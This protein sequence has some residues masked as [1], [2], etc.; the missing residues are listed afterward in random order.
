MDTDKHELLLKD[1]LCF[2]L[3]DCRGLGNQKDG[4]RK[5][6]KNSFF[7]A[8]NAKKREGRQQH[9]RNYAPSL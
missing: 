7:T 1:D 9:L 5:R 8:K 4:K 2:Y 6:R 3:S